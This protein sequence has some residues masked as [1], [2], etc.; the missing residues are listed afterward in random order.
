MLPPSARLVHVGPHKTGTT[1]LQRSLHRN[2]DGLHRHGVHYAGPSP[3][4]IVATLAVTGG[5]GR[6]GDREPKPEDWTRLTDEIRDAG[7]QRVILSS[8]F[9]DHA[10]DEAA[11]RVVRE[12]TGGPVHIVVTLRPIGKIVPSQWQQWVQNG[13]RTPY[14]EWLR[15]LLPEPPQ[16]STERLF[17]HRH[18]HGEQVRR[19]ADAVGPENLTVIVADD[20][21]PDLLSH[22]FESMVG[23]PEGMLD[24][25]DVSNRSLTLGEIEMVREINKQFAAHDWKGAWSEAVH[26]NVMRE[27]AL[28]RMKVER[29]P[30]PG[31]PRMS[32]PA[33]AVER[34]NAR[35]ARDIE[36]I[37]STGVRVIGDLSSLAGVPV[38]TASPGEG[39]DPVRVRADA[40]AVA[41]FGAVTGRGASKRSNRSAAVVATLGALASGE[42]AVDQTGM[43]LVP[44]DV[45]ARTVVG[46]IEGHRAHTELAQLPRMSA[47]AAGVAAHAAAR[48]SGA[49]GLVPTRSLHDVAEVLKLD[50]DGTHRIDAG[51][52]KGATDNQ[53][54]ASSSADDVALDM[55]AVHDVSARNLL[56]IVAKRGVRR[57]RRKLRR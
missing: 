33:W 15:S 28:K 3:Q 37:E 2:R 13:R 44:V 40:L 22:T 36:I 42:E 52:R 14:L 24:R 6:K 25:T 47:A 8:E 49:T 46:A 19:W 12:V 43:A 4:P 45:A 21:D 10:D 7:D 1:S 20:S 39:S 55:L 56:A 26:A 11:R 54:P 35:G 23:L 30:A 53:P 51:A 9:F 5:P 18:S 48:A 57:M 38:D 17:W 16:E 29:R 31:E 50:T 34:A 41:V 27:G 32:T